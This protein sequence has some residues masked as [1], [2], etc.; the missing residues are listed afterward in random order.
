MVSEREALCLSPGHERRPKLL[1]D[2]AR[3]VKDELDAAAQFCV[4]DF[5]SRTLSLTPAP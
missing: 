3:R 2:H 1:A 4:E 5:H